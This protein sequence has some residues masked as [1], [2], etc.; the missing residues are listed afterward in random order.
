M[1]LSTTT[2]SRV[3]K[4]VDNKG[5]YVE[6]NYAECRYTECRRSSEGAS[7]SIKSRVQTL[8]CF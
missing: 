5:R 3:G 7:G 1:T 6:Y 4:E 2:F 8:E